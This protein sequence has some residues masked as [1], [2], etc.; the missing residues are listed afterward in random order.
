MPWFERPSAMS[1]STSRSRGE[2]GKRVVAPV[3]REQR[4]DDDRVDRR[5]SFRNPPD[6][7]DELLDVAD[8]ILEQV[9]GAVGR[10]GQQLHRQSDLDVLRE[11]EHAHRGV[12]GADLQGGLHPLVVVC[13]RGR[14][15]TMATSGE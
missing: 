4:R 3:S 13:R 6:R 10:V 1:S 8:A 7:A 9:A 2:L 14:M 5:A 12:I 15:S 11:H